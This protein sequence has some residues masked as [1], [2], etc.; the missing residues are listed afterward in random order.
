MQPILLRRHRQLVQ[1][2]YDLYAVCVQQ[3]D[4]A[5]VLTRAELALHRLGTRSLHSPGL[6]A[7]RMPCASGGTDVACR[8]KQRKGAVKQQAKFEPEGVHCGAQD[9]QLTR[10][11]VPRPALQVL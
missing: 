6:G 2:I 9:G 4:G 10:C 7:W 3:R 11:S 8:I 5:G 1:S